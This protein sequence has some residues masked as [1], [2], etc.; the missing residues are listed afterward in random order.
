M[1]DILTV[2]GLEKSFGSV[3]AA[4]NISV[5]V[6]KEQTVG[7]IGANGAGKTTFV[8]MITGFLEPSNG[9]ILFE[10]R[11]IT[12]VPPLKVTG[13][14]V[15]RSF[16][17][18]QVFPSLSALSNLCIALAIAR[19]AGRLIAGCFTRLETQKNREEAHEILKRYHIGNYAD[20]LA[21]YLPQGG[22]KLLD[23]AMAVAS[24]PRLLLLDEP[25]SG[26]SVEE[27]YAVMET[28]MQ[29]LKAQKI[30]VL[31]V[32]HDME[33]VARYAER[34]LAFYDGAIIADGPADQTLEDPKVRELVIGEAFHR[35]VA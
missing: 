23:I 7:I 27:K 1:S 25:T 33:I 28:I 3:V 32:E 17:V 26:I 11:D 13:L 9:K 12:G 21:G 2:E 34:I 5:S 15:C 18:S 30:T 8:N 16:Q 4:K 22:R 35:S 20:T 29:A 10:G 14:G 24:R 6:T 31:F 19:T